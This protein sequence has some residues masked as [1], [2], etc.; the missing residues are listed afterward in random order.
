MSQA[1]GGGAPAKE[2][3]WRGRDGLE[4]SRKNSTCGP[5]GSSLPQF[6]HVESGDSNSPHAAGCAEDSEGKMSLEHMPVSSRSGWC[7]EG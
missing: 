5:T 2:R 7:A 1:A 3:P 4:K 6:L